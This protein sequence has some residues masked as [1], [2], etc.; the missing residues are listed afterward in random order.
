MSE[1]ETDSK[2]VLERTRSFEESI[3]K[4]DK[5]AI[6]DDFNHRKAQFDRVC[7]AISVKVVA[8][9][10]YDQIDAL[11][12]ELYPNRHRSQYR[13]KKALYKYLV[14]ELKPK[15]CAWCGKSFFNPRAQCCS[16]PCTTSLQRSDP[17]VI[18]KMLDTWAKH[19]GGHPMRNPKILKKIG[20]HFEAKYGKGIRA[21]A[22]IPGMKELREDRCLDKRGVRHHSMDPEVFRKQQRSLRKL[23]KVWIQGRYVYL[24]GYEPQVAK[25]ILSENKLFRF[26]EVDYGVPYVYAEE[27][28]TYHPDF[29]I[30]SRKSRYVV[31]VKSVFTLVDDWKVNMKKFKAAKAYAEAAGKVFLLAVYFKRR[32]ETLYI[33]NPTSKSILEELKPRCPWLN[34]STSF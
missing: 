24:R 7:A 27:S 3:P 34:F 19:P 2:Y 33:K 30:Q 18:A 17:A 11:A 29:E 4:L 1:I 6:E 9:D 12:E 10:L 25:E 16:K 8:R 23:K 32:K 5:K 20:D 28:H 31:E 15:Q 21:A 22:Q 13:Y 14:G 26:I